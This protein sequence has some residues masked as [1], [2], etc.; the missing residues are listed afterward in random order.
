[1]LDTVAEI[2]TPE[3]VRFRYRLAGPTLRLG[4][5]LADGFVRGLV[6]GGLAIALS[7]FN[8]F[9]EKNNPGTGL[10]FLGAF[11]LEWGYFV[12]CETLMGGRSIGKRW[13]D[14][15]VVKEDGRPVGFGDSF[16][17]NLLRAADFLPMG[18]AVGLLVSGTDKRFRRL[19]DLVAKTMVICE[20]RTHSIVP[21][22]LSPPAQT[23]ELHALPLRPP[24][25]TDERMAIEALLRRT[26]LSHDRASELA[27]IIAPLLAKRMGVRFSDP[28]RFLGLVHLRLRGVSS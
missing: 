9:D 14:L 7:A 2:E 10:L 17:R 1:M 23:S 3:H 5:W 19:G 6:I 22:T 18:Y 28:L 24:V 16:L 20:T 13:L 4:A 26:Q 21:L 15:R 11:L 8:V 12:A 25:S 27:E